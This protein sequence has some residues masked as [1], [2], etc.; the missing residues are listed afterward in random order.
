MLNT[1][2]SA[3]NKIFG[4]IL[5]SFERAA[6]VSL[7]TAVYAVFACSVQWNGKHYWLYDIAK[8]PL[9]RSNTNAFAM[10]NKNYWSLIA[11]VLE[12]KSATI[13]KAEHN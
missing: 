9:L 11:L 4:A 13:G 3:H 6:I 2:R 5:S 12:C 7:Y 1:P 10:Q 8:V